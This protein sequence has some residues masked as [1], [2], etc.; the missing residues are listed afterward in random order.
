MNYQL[1][2]VV[3]KVGIPCIFEASNLSESEFD[4]MKSKIP[5]AILAAMFLAAPANGQE[6]NLA[7]DI[8]SITLRIE[9]AERTVARFNGG[10]IRTDLSPRSPPALRGV[11]GVMHLPPTLDHVGLDISGCC[12]LAPNLGPCRSRYFRLPSDWRAGFTF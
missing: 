11:L 4:F 10:V 3:S 9:D 5:S 1:P 6:T 2:Q 12:A 8:S 7:A